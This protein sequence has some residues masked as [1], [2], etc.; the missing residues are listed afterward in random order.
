MEFTYDLHLLQ[1]LIGDIHRLTGISISLLDAKGH[2]LVGF[3]QEGNYCA[4][5]QK[6][7]SAEKCIK[8][9]AALLE[10]CSKTKKLEHHLCH[11]G[12]YDSAMPIMKGDSVAGFILM[13]QVRSER[14]PQRNDPL[15]ETLPQLGEEQI[16]SLYNLLPHILFHS[17]IH[18]KSSS[19]A[20]EL[21]AFIHEHLSER[22]R[23]EDLSNRFHRSK[24]TLHRAFSAHFGQ[25]INEYI[26]A[27][28]IELAKNLLRKSALSIGEIAEQ[29]GMESAYFSR[30]FKK[31]AGCS[32][33]DFRKRR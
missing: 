28:R 30:L 29:C 27:K 6:N 13:G 14:S 21:A 26:L 11:Q 32:P 22:L 19:L 33:M 25:G 20:E 5:I 8:S 10:K 4:C 23:V 1:Q 2:L 9:D 7:G 12:L 17:A 31:K 24:N 15:Y 18:Q 3:R 16:N